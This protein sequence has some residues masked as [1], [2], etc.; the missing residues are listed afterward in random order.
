MSEQQ[1]R[2]ATDFVRSLSQSVEGGTRFPPSAPACGYVSEE[3]VF[4]NL[5]FDD[6]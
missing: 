1:W 4:V 6:V 3:D 2:A 5:G